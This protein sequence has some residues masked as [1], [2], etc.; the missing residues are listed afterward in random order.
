MKKLEAKINE[1]VY[2]KERS[3]TRVQELGEKLSL[4]AEEKKEYEKKIKILEKE[5]K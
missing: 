3:E 2:E 5:Q 4:S 1:T